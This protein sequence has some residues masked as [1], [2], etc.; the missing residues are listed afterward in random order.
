MIKI[1][2]NKKFLNLDGNEGPSEM[3]K[4]LADSFAKSQGDD[5]VKWLDWAMKMFQTGIIEVDE[6]DHKKIVDFIL[7][8]KIERGISGQLLKE[9]EKK[10]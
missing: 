6:S 7:G 1:N 2:L 4:F 10:D 8:L 5:P 9:I 3:H